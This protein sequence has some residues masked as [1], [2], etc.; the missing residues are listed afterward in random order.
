MNDEC[1]VPKIIETARSTKW[2]QQYGTVFSHWTLCYF[3]VKLRK[4]NYVMFWMQVCFSNVTPRIQNRPKWGPSCTSVN[5]VRNSQ[6]HSLGDRAP[7]IDSTHLPLWNRCNDMV[8]SGILNSFSKEITVRILYSK[9]AES[10]MNDLEDRF[11]QSNGGQTV[12]PTKR[13]QR[14]CSR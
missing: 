4:G 5:G 12:S 11:G 10:L 9:T 14:F 3:Q 1:C 7:S 13:Y 8:T 6:N 2:E